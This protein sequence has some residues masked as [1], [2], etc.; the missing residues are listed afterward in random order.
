MA[1]ARALNKVAFDHF[2]NGRLDEAIAVYRQAVEADPGLASA[3]EGL[4]RAL[5]RK[6]ELDSAIEAAQRLVETF[7][8]RG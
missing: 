5:D 2:A 3:W 1:D 8:K 6:G 4:A 7:R